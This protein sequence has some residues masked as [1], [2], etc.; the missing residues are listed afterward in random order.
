MNSLDQNTQQSLYPELHRRRFLASS[1]S[2]AIGCALGS[3]PALSHAATVHTLPALPY[4]DDA[5]APVISSNTISFHYGK[6][7]KA[8]I[9]NLNG[10]ITN[11]D[12]ANMPIEAIIASAKDAP[13]FN[14]AAQAYNHTFYWYGMK[15]PVEGSDN[16][17][18][19]HISQALNEAFGDFESFKKQFSEVGAKHFGSGWAWLLKNKAGKLEIKGMHDASTP[20]MD[21]DTP[22]LALDVWEHAYYV[23]YRNKRPDYITAFWHLINWEFVEKQ[24]LKPSDEP[25][26]V[27][28]DTPS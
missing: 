20:V 26:M 4:A 24:L 3:F 23:D 11:T 21:G 28:I 12:Y 9:D 10:F 25:L 22:L 27:A 16:L 6:H 8:Y 14:N 2:I 18:S 7:H 5:L 1:A 19:D 15:S 13:I 17:P